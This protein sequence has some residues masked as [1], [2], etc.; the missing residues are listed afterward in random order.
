MHLTTKDMI[1]GVRYIRHRGKVAADTGMP[2]TWYTVPSQSRNRLLSNLRAKEIKGRI[3]SDELSI[4]HDAKAHPDWV[5]VYRQTKHAKSLAMVDP[6]MPVLVLGK[7]PRARESKGN[8]SEIHS[9]TSLCLCG[10]GQQARRRFL[11]GHDAKLKRQLRL[12]ALPDDHIA[13][14]LEAEYRKRWN[15]QVP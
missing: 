13:K 6:A 14:S 12:G 11:P 7:T 2:D 4:L 1:R 10:C 9:S 5:L 15:M 3:R 8:A